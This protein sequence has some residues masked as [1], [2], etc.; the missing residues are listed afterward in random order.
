MKI[1][2]KYLYCAAFTAL[3]LGA[4]SSCSDKTDYEPAAPEN[5][6][7][8]YFAQNVKT[9]YDLNEDE[10][11][12][13]I[14]MFRSSDSGSITV[15]IT[16]TPLEGNTDDNAFKFPSSVTF[17]DGSKTA[18][19]VVTYDMTGFD[20]N[21]GGSFIITIDEASATQ[22]GVTSITITATYPEP[23]NKVGE[24]DFYDSYWY[25]GTDGQYYYYGATV[26]IEQNALNPTLYRL[27]NPYFW[28]DS[29]EEEYFVFKLLNPGDYYGDVQVPEDFPV[30]VVAYN[31]LKIDYYEDDSGYHGEVYIY[32]PGSL[33]SGQDPNTWA[34]NYV[35][36][37]AAD[38]TPGVIALTPLYGFEMDG[39]IYTFNNVP[40]K[41]IQIVF[42]G[43]ELLD[44]SVEVTYSGMFNKADG[45]LE[46]VA[47]VELGEDVEQAKVAII[48]GSYVS[49][50][51]DLIDN[52]TI[53][54]ETITSSQTLNIPFSAANEEGKYTIVAVTYYNGE[55]RDSG[56]YTFTYTPGGG[57][58]W[59]FIT[60]GT[61]YF[62]EKMWTLDQQ[63]YLELY[64]SAT[65][66]GK[67]K[68]E[69]WLNN[70]TFR[71]TMDSD[72]YILVADQETGVES[73]YGMIYI[74]DLVD[75]TGDPS[76]GESYYED[77]VYNFAIIYYVDGG[78]FDYGYEAFVPDTVTRSG[79]VQTRSNNMRNF[80]DI[81]LKMKLQKSMHFQSKVRRKGMLKMD[82]LAQ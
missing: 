68:I 60:E 26:E 36:D 37:W 59:N 67:F 80:E 5:G 46:V 72:G 77:G 20:Y 17:E 15:P 7:G 24:G 63:P 53:Q 12:F 50:V 55:V 69:G 62:L 48:K 82:H 3:T 2:N 64:E 25:L 70:G 81:T 39:A 10:N 76:L 23:W 8:A 21:D 79:D 33:S 28:P 31:P 16:V 9:Q 43:F 1:T 56:Y 75:Y 4:L 11:T 40:A 74:D 61:Y 6:A 41:C 51:V 54:S 44:T 66:P 27:T 22:Y 18:D 30:T 14:P 73:D 34:T 47:D 71:F 52:G 45:T 38:G 29:S 35:Q 65:T 42:P 32:F 58:T 19:I 13:S 49:S 78:Y 57:D